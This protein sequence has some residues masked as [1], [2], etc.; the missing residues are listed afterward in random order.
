M[1][2]ALVTHP[3]CFNHQGPAGHPERPAR[4]RAVLDGLAELPL[5]RLRANAATREQLQRVHTPEMVERVLDNIP[6]EI[7][8]GE[9]AQIDA[10]TYLSGRSADAAMCAAGAVVAAVDSVLSGNCPQCFLCDPPT[11]PSRGAGPAYGLLSL[12]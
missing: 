3:A 1:Q 2:T 11:W 7:G 10:D 4:L 5:I 8:Q 12:Q 9:Y 6:R